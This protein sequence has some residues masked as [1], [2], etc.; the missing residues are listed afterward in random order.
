MRKKA[1][2]RDLALIVAKAAG[3]F[4]ERRLIVL[5]VYLCRRR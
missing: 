1:T 4:D 5:S 3:V 2:N